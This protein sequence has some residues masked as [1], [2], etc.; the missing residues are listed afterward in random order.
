MTNHKQTDRSQQRA[1]PPPMEA[2]SPPRWRLLDEVDEAS[3][4]SFPASDPPT[5][6]AMTAGPPR[7]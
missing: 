5:W 4:E 2:E 3:R 1:N 6:S 7:T